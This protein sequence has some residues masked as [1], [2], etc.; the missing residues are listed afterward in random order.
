MY[1]S[2]CGIPFLIQLDGD[3]DRIVVNIIVRPDFALLQ[4]PGLAGC[5][6]FAA[7]VI[8][9]C[10]FSCR[11]GAVTIDGNGQAEFDGG[12]YRFCLPGA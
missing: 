5:Y 9:Q 12:A 11:L 1:G 4:F 8:A 3:V 7:P 2:H 6:A 10:G